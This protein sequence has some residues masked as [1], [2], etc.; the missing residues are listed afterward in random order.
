[1]VQKQKDKFDHGT[2]GLFNN[3]HNQRLRTKANIMIFNF[4]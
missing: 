3:I 1:M 2:K 4:E